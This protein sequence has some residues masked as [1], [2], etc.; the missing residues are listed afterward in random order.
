MMFDDLRREVEGLPET[1]KI[2]VSGVLS[3][4]MKRKLCKHSPEEISRIVLAAIEEVNNGSVEPLD[5][6]IKKRLQ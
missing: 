4:N 2:Q 3:E 5:R 6:L 1:A